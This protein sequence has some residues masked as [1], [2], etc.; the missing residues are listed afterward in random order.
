MSRRVGVEPQVGDVGVGQPGGEGPVPDPGGPEERLP[1][2]HQR[3]PGRVL[4]HQPVDLAP[5]GGA[6]LVVA[7]LVGLVDQVVDLVVVVAA[8]VVV[9]G[10]GDGAAVQQDPDDRAA[11]VAG[12]VG[13]DP[14]A[15]QVVLF[16]LGPQAQR[17]AVGV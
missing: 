1:V 8:V 13:T 12:D 11:A 7:G 4:H 15:S 5:E 3:R 9:G 16:A 17:I 10:R 14:G 6:G 2:V